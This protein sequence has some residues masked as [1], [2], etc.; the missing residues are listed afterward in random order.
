MSGALAVLAV[1][2]ASATAF[3]VGFDK[4]RARGRI[5]I[6]RWWAEPSPPTP[7]QE[8]DPLA[9]LFTIDAREVPGKPKGMQ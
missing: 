6:L 5:E 7:E 1:V 9:W 8:A 4:G 3:S 2:V